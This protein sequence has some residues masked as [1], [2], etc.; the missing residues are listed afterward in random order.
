MKSTID[1][2]LTVIVITSTLVFPS[3]KRDNHFL[4]KWEVDVQKTLSLNDFPSGINQRLYINPSDHVI[5][6][7]LAGN[8]NEKFGGLKFKGSWS[9]YDTD[10]AV[11]RLE[12][13]DRIKN[14][15]GHLNQ[16]IKQGNKSRHKLTRLYQRM[17]KVNRM[18]VRTYTY[19]DG[20]IHL[21]QDGMYMVLVFRKVA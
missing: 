7:G 18:S 14:F 20:N 2:V 12:S 15:K 5:N 1:F 9:R 21:K 19:K 13:D 17:H 10:L 6:F 11:A 4:G 8:Y 3:T 16:K